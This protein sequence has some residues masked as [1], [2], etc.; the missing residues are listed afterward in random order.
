M[1]NESFKFPAFLGIAVILNEV[2]ILQSLVSCHYKKT[3]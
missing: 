3:T 2:L 1:M